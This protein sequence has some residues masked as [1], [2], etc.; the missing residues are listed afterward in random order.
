MKIL[1]RHGQ[2]EHNL[3]NWISC[4]L[5][6]KSELTEEGR[7]I[8]R[9]S[10]K[11]LEKD[12]IMFS[13]FTLPSECKIYSSPLLRTKQTAEIICDV[14]GIDLKNIVYDE[15]LKEVNYGEYDEGPVN[16]L[17]YDVYDIDKFKEQGSETYEDVDKRVLDFMKEEFNPMDTFI[18]VSH[19]L[20]IRE[21]HKM[22]TGIDDKIKVAEYFTIHYEK[23]W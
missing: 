10:A 22:M 12:L 1:F 18:V 5:D 7:K 15:R 23:Y 8:V 9:E 19:A 16:R 11:K 21:M 14:L 20:P 17:P 3:K 2:C 4:S 13:L 6:S